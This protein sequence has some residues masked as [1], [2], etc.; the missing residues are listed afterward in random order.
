MALWGAGA[1]SVLFLN[2]VNHTDAIGCV[3]DINPRKHGS[4]LPGTGHRVEAPTALASFDAE[5]I[6]LM[7]PNYREEVASDLREMGASG[8]LVLV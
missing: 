7:N 1:K 8:G 6:L 4:W 5:E 3:V 2:M